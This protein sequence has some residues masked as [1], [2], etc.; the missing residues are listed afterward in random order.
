MVTVSS[1]RHWNKASSQNDD[2]DFDKAQSSWLKTFYRWLITIDGDPE[3][4]KGRVYQSLPN[5]T[6][7]MFFLGGRFRTVRCRSNLAIFTGF[8]VVAPMVLFSIF[9]T[10][11]IWHS[12]DGYKLLVIFFYYFWAMCLSFFVRTA[13]S[14]PGILPRNI[15]LGQLKRNFQIP[16]EYYSTISL[17]A[18]QTIRGDIQAKIELKYCTSC[19]IWRPP[20]A[21]HCSTC[22]ACILTHD[23]HCI[24]VN[25]C[26]GQRNYRYFILFLASA[27]LSS[28]FLIANCSIHIYHHRN[29]PSKVPVTILL[30]I[31]GGLAIIYPM[32]LLI[33]HILMTGRQ[34]T[35]REFLREA[36]SKNPIFTKI[37]S[38]EHNPFDRGNFTANMLSL[39]LQP[40]GISTICPQERHGDRDWR[41]VSVADFHSFEK[42]ET[43]L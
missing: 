24:W 34:Q 9:E 33:Y 1:R 43:P 42:M 41:F 8:T 28:I 23:H 12:R 36:N 11:R 14:D 38:I 40:R 26:I 22:E 4:N 7:Y 39:I 17:P 29:L 19:R 30:L 5:V 6:N 25:N 20:R 21:S 15:H 37:H 27:I 10:G 18:P 16:Q 32:L 2:V 3:V 35:T 31:Y 13:T